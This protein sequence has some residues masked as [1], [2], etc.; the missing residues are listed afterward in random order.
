M[1]D[2]TAT[3][4]G[5]GTNNNNGCGCSILWIILLLSF[6]G[7][8]NGCGSS[9]F[10]GDS[11]C[12]CWIILLL[13]FC[14]NGL[15]GSNNNSGCGC[16][17]WFFISLHPFFRSRLC[18]AYFSVTMHTQKWPRCIIFE[19]KVHKERICAHRMNYRNC[20]STE[21]LWTFMKERS[22]YGAKGHQSNFGFWYAVFQ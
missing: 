2:L 10:N 21:Q 3:S 22:L 1:S 6:C 8:G 12:G 13:L 18:G 7:N 20:E 4:C 9:L 5:C 19:Y 11:D 17:C 14:G 15:C 16:G